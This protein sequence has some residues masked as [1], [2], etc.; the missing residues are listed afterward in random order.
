MRRSGEGCWRQEAVSADGAWLL[1]HIRLL[2]GK[3]VRC[4]A[5]NS[6]CECDSHSSVAMAMRLFLCKVKDFSSSSSKIRSRCKK[7]KDQKGTLCTGNNDG[8]I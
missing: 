3:Q 7:V 6:F 5:K 8:V 4:I 1:A 2:L